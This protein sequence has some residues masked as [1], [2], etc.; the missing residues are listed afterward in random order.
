M[1]L[2]TYE[3]FL[4]LGH[5]YNLTLGTATRLAAMSRPSGAGLGNPLRQFDVVR[6]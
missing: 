1:A 4:A 3:W 5:S 6:F 2:C